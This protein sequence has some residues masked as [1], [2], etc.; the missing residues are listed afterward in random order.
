MIFSKIRAVFLSACFFFMLTTLTWAA[1]LSIN[2]VAVNASDEVKKVPVHSL[3]DL[4][5]AAPEPG[6]AQFPVRGDGFVKLRQRG[7]DAVLRR[8]QKSFD[9]HRL[10]VTRRQFQRAIRCRQGATRPAETQFQFRHARPAKRE[11]RRLRHRRAGRGQG[12]LQL[13]TRLGVVGTGQER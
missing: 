4:D 7:G 10:R 13:E 6:V 1:N 5:Q 11:V 12:R 2:L 3:T 8:Q 9:R